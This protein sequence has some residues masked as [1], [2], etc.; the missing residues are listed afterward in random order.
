[1]NRSQQSVKKRP[2][3]KAA[4]EPPV[5]SLSTGTRVRLTIAGALVVL[6]G[7]IFL[8]NTIM[9]EQDAIPK[10]DYQSLIEEMPIFNLFLGNHQP[11]PPNTDPRIDWVRVKAPDGGYTGIE[12]MCDSTTLIYRDDSA[13]RGETSISTEDDSPECQPVH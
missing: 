2:D 6:T 10:N 8:L 13:P 11:S 1:M 5:R 3:T 9:H 4:L 7:S 12:K